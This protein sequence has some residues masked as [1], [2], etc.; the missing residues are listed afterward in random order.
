MISEHDSWWGGCR[1]RG[2][3]GSC[4]G[5]NWNCWRRRGGNVAR[6]WPAFWKMSMPNSSSFFCFQLKPITLKLLGLV[7]EQQQ[8]HGLRLFTKL[9]KPNL[10]LTL[11]WTFILGMETINDIEATVLAG[12]WRALSFCLVHLFHCKP[13]FSDSGDWGKL[14]A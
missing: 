6:H 5:G 2:R 10:S 8:K 13:K 4:L 1:N 3:G 9:K 14:L 7:R 12:Q 11:L